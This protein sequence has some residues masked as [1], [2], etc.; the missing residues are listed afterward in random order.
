[1]S[2]FLTKIEENSMI[3]SNNLKED[4]KQKLLARVHFKSTNYPNILYDRD[5]ITDPVK[6]AK[7]KT[8]IEAPEG[9]LEEHRGTT[10]VFIL[11]KEKT[12]Q[13]EQNRAYNRIIA[14]RVNEI[15]SE[16]LEEAETSKES[17][18]SI[19]NRTCENLEKYNE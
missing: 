7:L 10:L 12:A 19:V 3:I 14:N 11:S 2:I 6:R 17:L 4:I 18:M 15:L 5:I 9:Y 8:P 13:R 1:M 16:I